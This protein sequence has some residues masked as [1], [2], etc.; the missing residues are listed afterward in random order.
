MLLIENMKF[1]STC[2]LDLIGTAMRLLVFRDS[3]GSCTTCR[4]CISDFALR[5]GTRIVLMV[6]SIWRC[7]TFFENTI[8]HQVIH[9]ALMI[10]LF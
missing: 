6:E 3:G 9:F 2:Q 1:L 10:L 5:K 7:L 4:S 8:I